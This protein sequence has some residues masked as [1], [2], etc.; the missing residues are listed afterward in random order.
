MSRAAVV[1]RLSLGGLA[2]GMVLLLGAESKQASPDKAKPKAAPAYKLSGPYVHDNLTLYLI[3]GEDLLKGKKLLTLDEA[4]QQKKVKIYETG[5]VNQ[6]SIENLDAGVEVFVQSGDIIK[7]GQQDRIITFDLILPPK[8]GKMALNAFCVEA[9]RWSQRGGESK[10]EFSS[11]REQASSKGLKIAARKDKEQGKVWQGVSRDQMRLMRNLNK[12]TQDPRSPSS[13]QLTLENKD[14]NKAV[15]AYLKKVAPCIDGKNDVIGL[16]VAI[17]GEMSCADVYGSHELFLKLWPKLI[18][19]SAVEAVVE[20]KK[21][22][23]FKPMQEETVK[24][25]L[26]DAEKGQK[27]EKKVTGHLLEV[28][29]ETQENLLYETRDKSNPNAPAAR[30]S[31]IKK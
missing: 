9:G 31:Y 2:L 20:L 7:G 23:K 1:R 30:R 10:T 6:L 18:K 28:Q 29:R 8:S 4:L 12:Q 17:N 26:A 13:L 14:V 11:S 21:D 3:H 15:E 19:A 27:T 24:A 25:F 22:K 16:A 5:N